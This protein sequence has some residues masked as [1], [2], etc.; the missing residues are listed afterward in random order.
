MFGHIR[1]GRS[2]MN[3]DSVGGSPFLQFIPPPP[4]WAER[5]LHICSRPLCLNKALRSIQA[6]GE[7]DRDGWSV[8]YRQ[9]TRS[10]RRTNEETNGCCGRAR[11]IAWAA[12]H[13]RGVRQPASFIFL[14]HYNT[15]PRTHPAPYHQSIKSILSEPNPSPPPSPPPFQLLLPPPHRRHH[16]QRV[17]FRRARGQVTGLRLLKRGPPPLLRRAAPAA[18]TAIGVMQEGGDVQDVVLVGL[19]RPQGHRLFLCYFYYF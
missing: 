14:K 10:K 3:S 7:V 1:R 11:R 12:R 17:A 5:R 15:F 19:A 6:G 9:P 8:G 4:E 16:V 18:A 13:W 2:L